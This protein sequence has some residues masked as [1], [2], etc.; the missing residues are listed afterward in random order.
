[1]IAATLLWQHSCGEFTRIKAISHG[2]CVDSFR[3][4][5]TLRGGLYLSFYCF[6]AIPT[7]SIWLLK[8]CKYVGGKAWEIWSRA[9][10]QGGGTQGVVPNS[11]SSHFMLNG[12]MNDERYLYTALLTLWPQALGLIV[13]EKASRFF[14]RHHSPCFYPLLFWFPDP[15]ITLTPRGRVWANELYFSIAKDFQSVWILIRV[16]RWQ[17]AGARQWPDMSD[18]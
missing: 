15:S 10:W 8:V 18:E 3:W 4:T 11:N 16:S 9:G 14:F 7:S 12:A 13:K 6:Q 1:M 17:G 5:C 2:Y